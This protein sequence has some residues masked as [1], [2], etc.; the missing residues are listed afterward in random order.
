[1]TAPRLIAP[2]AAHQIDTAR[3]GEYLAHHVEGFDATLR[4]R[5][6]QGGQSNPTYLLESDTRKAVLRKKPPGILLPSAHQ[7][8]REFRIQ[9]ALAGSGVPVAAMLHYCAEESVIGTAFYVMD[10]LEGRVFTDVLM[11][12]LL[13]AERKAVQAAL[14]EAIGRLHAVDYE[15]LGLGDFGRPSKYVERQLTRWRA[16]Y[17][18]AKTEGLPAMDRLMDWLGRNIPA[19]DENAIAH[20]DFRLGNMMVHPRAPVI[21]AVL[22]WELATLGHPLADLAYCCSPFHLPAGSGPAMTGYGGVDLAAHGLASED[23]VLDLYCR[24]TGRGEI[25]DWRFFLAFSLFRSAAIVE[26]VYARALAGNAADERGIAMHEMT[27]ITSECGWRIVCDG[28]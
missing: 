20:G 1:M 22:D 19:A 14:F 7:I 5:Q 23:E 9:K 25:K 28:N 4:V 11:G 12:E 24:V 2:L 6:F 21:T 10:Y 26:G 3:L 16:Q 18:A 8:D 15:A 13:P 27:K 17:E